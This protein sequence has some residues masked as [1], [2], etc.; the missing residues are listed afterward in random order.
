MMARP[1]QGRH[2]VL[3]GLPGAGK[4][5]VGKLLATMLGRPFVDIDDEI[6]R[7]AGQSI[8]AVFEHHGEAHF[9]QLEAEAT[10][11]LA[12]QSPSVVATG[13]GW[14]TNTRARAALSSNLIDLIYLRTSVGAAAQRLANDTAVRPLI[15]GRIAE[16]ALSELLEQRRSAYESAPRVVDTDG[17]PPD[18]VAK[19]VLNAVLASV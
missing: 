18:E 12:T 13:G 14:M 3:V 2:V 19:K 11:N 5:T 6:E 9:R 4:S 16:K 1:G 8:Q 17:A 7:I 10:K 15:R